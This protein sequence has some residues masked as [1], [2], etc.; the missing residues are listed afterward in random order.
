MLSGDPD[1]IDDLKH[2][3]LEKQHFN[4]FIAFEE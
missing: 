3:V 4:C 2:V 1:P